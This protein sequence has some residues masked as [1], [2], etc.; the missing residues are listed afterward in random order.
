MI[1]QIIDFS[2]KNRVIIFS[3][4]A[5]AA[6][7]GWWSMNRIS[8]DAIPDLSDTQVI[9]YSRW[10]RSPDII[11]DQ[12]TYPI[13]TAMLGTPKVRAVRGFSDFGYSFI[14]VIFEDGTD[15][16]W[17]RSRTLEY[18]SGV[19]SRLPDGVK[20]ELGPD[21]TGLGWIFQY[22]LV[23]TSGKH[24]LADM[25]SY[26]DWYLRYYL[27]SVPGVAE[28]A[29]VGGFVKQY[30]VN[31]DPNRLQAYG[32]SIKRVI[33]A[34]QGSNREV[35]AR[36]IEF[37]GTE[38]MIRGRGYAQSI[39]DFENIVLEAGEDGSPIRIKDVGQVVLGPDIRR[40]IAELDGKGEVVSGIIVMRQGK[41]ALQVIDQV[42]AKIREIEPGLP[43]SVKIV[44]VYDR[45]E[46]IRSSI[47]TLKQTLIEV[48]LTV[49]LIILLFLWHFPSAMIPVITIP[50][51]VLI[52]FI[53]FR[54]LGIT[55]NIMS[56]GG[57]AIAI[58]TMVDAAI[59]V[60][61][62]THKK[63]EEWERTGRKED[64]RAVIVTAI[65]QVASPS[66]FALLVIAVSFLP[67]LTLEAEEGRLFKPLAYTKTLAMVVAA[68]LAITLDPALRLFITHLRNFD[69]RP[70]WISR[71]ANAV[72]VGR[73]HSENKHPISRVLIRFYEPIAAWTLRR[74]WIVITAA[75]ALVVATI[76]VY[77]KLGSEFMPPLDEGSLFYMPTTMPGISITVAQKILQV[78]DRILKQFPEVDRVLGKAGRAETSTDPA[79][80]S[81]LET[82]ITL[83]PK[84]KW[85]Q[86]KTWYTSWAPQWLRSIFR[87]ITPDHISTQ[88]LI[89]EMNEAL[90]IPGLTNSWTM[91]IK[92]R[93]DMLTTG[94]RTPVG[95][96]ISGSDL[97]EIEKIGI[98]V[99]SLLSSVEGTRS[100]FAERT[101]GGYF[102]DIDWDREELAR[103][104]LSIEEAQEVVAKALGGE[105]V[106]VAIQGRERY[107]VNIRYMRDFRTD[108]GYLSRILIPASGGKKQIP[109][110]QLAAIKETTGPGMIRN[111]DGLLTGYVYVDVAGRDVN[112][113]IRETSLLI[114]EEVELPAGYAILWSGQHEAMQRVK[115]R[116]RVI[117]PL[118]L[119]LI[120]LL[121]YLNTRSITKTFIVLLAV[122]F[123]AIG[124]LWLLYLLGYNM[125]IGVWVGLIALLGVDAET[126]VFML[127]YLDLAYEQAK[128]EN[129]L[130]SLADLRRAILDGAVN[131]LRPKFMT[132]STLAIGLIPIMW[133]VGTG[134]DV[135]K[136][137][138]APMIG[139]IFTSFLL[140][141]LVYP[142]IYQIW[143]WNFE[144]KKHLSSQE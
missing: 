22:A 67:V 29:P 60:V 83:H 85:R 135:M 13:V 21:A 114:R 23:D 69:F 82:V 110:T 32:L 88:D 112:D 79:P 109:L 42:K 35:G 105:N 84:S 137:I 116:L 143:K 107:P 10:D 98:R 119:F 3:L 91:P 73:I 131:R 144:M 121:L 24:S 57:I 28:V 129:R 113:Y 6:L 50:L 51:A 92:G 126:G 74:K 30:Q 53:P 17:A 140:E 40:G 2:V 27:K 132:V 123:S 38:Y 66:F 8:L 93:I 99:E 80:L 111:E 59:V 1:N 71:T 64:D 26:Q 12:V 20:T 94:I 87:H 43:E 46:L 48:I 31:L 101:G 68:F 128:K 97:N 96:K 52:S 77:T 14:Y 19:I 65:K 56:L 104:G 47:G 75:V 127:L 36:L 45:S 100:V 34:V 9:I 41:N 44:P 58:G 81:M 86:K 108:F 55:A 130:R 136:R 141:L 124:A 70:R 54:L 63:L 16:Y 5:V 33:E 49:V 78:T 15:I 39:R 95:L 138:A 18:L 115:E 7:A 117:L 89:T 102:L 139:G 133:S 62:Q 76:P 118:T 72:L 120:L 61:E 4:V 90:R 37:G 134:S 125:S 11:E 25:R 103:Y 106:T 142:A 122:P